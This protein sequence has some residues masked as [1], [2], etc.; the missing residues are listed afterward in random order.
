[1][2]LNEPFCQ[3]FGTRIPVYCDITPG[4]N[5]TSSST[6]P[7][8]VDVDAAYA[9]A[10]P[11]AQAQA[12]ARAQPKGPHRDT[13]QPPLQNQHKPAS[14]N[15]PSDSSTAHPPSGT[16][17]YEACGRLVSVERAD[18]YE[19]AFCNLLLAIIALTVLVLRSKKLASLRAGEL[20]ARIGWGWGMA[21]GGS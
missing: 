1:M 21:T 16:L 14:P 6:S 9:R 18:F 11:Q 15:L 3:P 13:L 10:H 20:K 4:H 2:Q 19:F 7:S 12:Q 5:D 8:D 17:A